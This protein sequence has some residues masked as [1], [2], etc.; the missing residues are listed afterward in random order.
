MYTGGSMNIT[1]KGKLWRVTHGFI[2]NRQ[3]KEIRAIEGTT[4]F[5]DLTYMSEKA[6]QKACKKAFETK[7]WD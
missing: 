3:T 7:K 2:E 5:H 1:D 6:F 4:P